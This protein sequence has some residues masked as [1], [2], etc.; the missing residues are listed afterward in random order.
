[1]LMW[2]NEILHILFFNSIRY[3][4]LVADVFLFAVKLWFEQPAINVFATIKC[5]FGN[6]YELC[7][8]QSN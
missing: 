5:S 1:M 6:T 2:G 3:M 8:R 4:N 7:K